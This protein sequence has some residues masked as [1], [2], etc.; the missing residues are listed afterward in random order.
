MNQPINFITD[1]EF[2]EQ[3]LNASHLVIV[4]FWADWC[5]KCKM[6][7]PLL[8]EVVLEVGDRVTIYKVDLDS[9][10]KLSERFPLFHVPALLFFKNGQMCDEITASVPKKLLLEKITNH[11]T[12]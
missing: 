5:G 10:P 6:I 9:E 4:N 3:V 8:E 12:T 2:D 7:D 11:T 1:A